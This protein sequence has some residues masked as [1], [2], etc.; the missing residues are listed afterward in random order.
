[1]F[2]SILF[3]V[4]LSS[5]AAHAACLPD[6]PELGDIGPD[7]QLVCMMLES[8]SPNSKISVIDRKIQS[9]KRMSVIVDVDGRTESLN[10]TLIGAD[11]IL[12]EPVLVNTN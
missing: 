7:S 4:L 10:Y 2:R 11:W 5:S 8:H 12:K 6:S 1:M 9:H 3:T